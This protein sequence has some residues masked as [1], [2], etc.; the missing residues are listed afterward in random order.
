MPLTG[1]S[2]ELLK[3]RKVITVRRRQNQNGLSQG[4]CACYPGQAG[5]LEGQTLSFSHRVAVVGG[6]DARS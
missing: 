3:I 5:F 4:L 6:T 2:R 1:R